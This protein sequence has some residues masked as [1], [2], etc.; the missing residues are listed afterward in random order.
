MKVKLLRDEVIGWI[1]IPLNTV[2]YGSE[3]SQGSEKWY[4][5]SSIKRTGYQFASNLQTKDRTSICSV[6][7]VA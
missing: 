3:N 1:D 4:H 5:L 7:L 2:P 6:Q